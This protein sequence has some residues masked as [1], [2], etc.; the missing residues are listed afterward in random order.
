MT[1]LALLLIP[2]VLGGITLFFLGEDRRLFR[3]KILCVGAVLHALGTASLHVPGLAF[4]EFY[5]I[6]CDSLGLLFLSLTSALFLAA[7]F[8]S[9]GY[10]HKVAPQ[11]REGVSHL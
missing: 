11:S 9:I 1:A 10:F 2:M 4:G 5:F 8:Y 6:T 3:R 7:S